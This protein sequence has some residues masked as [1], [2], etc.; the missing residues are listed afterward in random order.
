MDADRQMEANRNRGRR[1]LCGVSNFRLG[2]V[3]VVV[4]RY[5]ITAGHFF[6]LDGRMFD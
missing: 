6:E 5:R 3:Y 2:Y 4:Y 1:R